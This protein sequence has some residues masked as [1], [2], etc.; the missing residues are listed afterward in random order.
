MN[1]RFELTAPFCWY[2]RLVRLLVCLFVCLFVCW[3]VGWL[4]FFSFCWLA[5]VIFSPRQ[6]FYGTYKCLWIVK[7][8]EYLWST[9]RLR[10]VVRLVTD[11]RFKS[12]AI[13]KTPW[14]RR[15]FLYFPFPFDSFQLNLHQIWHNWTRWALPMNRTM[16]DGW[17][18]GLIS[19]KRKTNRPFGF[20][21]RPQIKNKTKKKKQKKKKI[22]SFVHFNLICVPPLVTAFRIDWI[23]PMKRATKTSNDCQDATKHLTDSF[24]L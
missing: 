12:G 18:L 1:F 9:N 6:G 11:V 8:I 17:N 4:V 3:L 5:K 13:S 22:A 24:S 7:W 20:V 2:V 16:E 23:I 14:N 10:Y 15:F 19:A 21:H